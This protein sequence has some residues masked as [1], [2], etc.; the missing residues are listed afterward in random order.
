MT[1]ALNLDAFCGSSN[2]QTNC[3]S[4]RS[5]PHDEPGGLNNSAKDLLIFETDPETVGKSHF[6]IIIS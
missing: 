6:H 4:Y 2:D 5:T 1:E 3:S